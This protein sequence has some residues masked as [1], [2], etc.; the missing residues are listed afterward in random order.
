MTFFK[1]EHR[2]VLSMLMTVL[3]VLTMMATSMVAPISAFADEALSILTNDNDHLALT[4]DGEEYANLNKGVLSLTLDATNTNFVV[5]LTF[6]LSEVDENGKVSAGNMDRYEISGG[7]ITRQEGLVTATIDSNAQ[8]ITITVKEGATKDDFTIDLIALDKRGG[9]SQDCLPIPVKL[10]I[11][12]YSYTLE[13]SLDEDEAKVELTADKTE[14]SLDLWEHVKYTI[15]ET[16]YSGDD[17]TN[18]ELSKEEIKFALGSITQGSGTYTNDN[19]AIVL[20]NNLLVVNGEKMPGSEAGTLYK[21]ELKVTANDKTK[22]GGGGDMMS[23]CDLTVIEI[24]NCITETYHVDDSAPVA[25]AANQKTAYKLADVVKQKVTIKSELNPNNT[26]KW[27]EISD[28]LVAAIDGNITKFVKISGDELHVLTPT[29]E[30]VTGE[31]GL[32]LTID[33]AKGINLT[34]N[35]LTLDVVLND[36]NGPQYTISVDPADK[37]VKKEDLASLSDDTVT[38]VQLKVTVKYKDVG[39]EVELTSGNAIKY[40]LTY[41]QLTD[42]ADFTLSEVTPGTGVFQIEFTKGSTS[43]VYET[44]FKLEALTKDDYACMLTNDSNEPAAAVKFTLVGANEYQIQKFADV[45][46]SSA[47][48]QI[49]LLDSVTIAKGGEALAAADVKALAD[50]KE[51]KF[52]VH[53]GSVSADDYVTV[54]GTNLTLI[55][56]NLS[57]SDL[58]F[59]IFVQLS[60]DH[61]IGTNPQTATLKIVKKTVT[62]GGGD[63]SGASTTAPSNPSTPGTTEPEPEP[64]IPEVVVEMDP[65]TAETG[66]DGKAVAE[67][68]AKA[69]DEAIAEAIAEAEAENGAPVVSIPVEVDDEAV[70]LEVVLPTASVEKLAAAANS[71]LKVT[72]RIGDVKLSH[73]ALVALADEVGENDTIVLE[74]NT[75]V[76]A[77]A[78]SLNEAQ[79]DKIV[80]I[81]EKLGEEAEAEIFDV[82][83]YV[84]DEPMHDFNNGAI[85]VSVPYELPA[86]V[87]PTSIRVY[88]LAEDGTLERCKDAS[89]ADG[90]VTFTTYHL[91]KYIIS[92]MS[93][94]AEFED[95]AES[96][97]FYDAVMWAYENGVTTGKTNTEFDPYDG[98]TRAQF[99]T[100]LWRAAGYPEPTTTECAF[101]DVENAGELEP[102]YKAILWAAENGIALGTDAEGTTFSPKTVVLRGQAL[103]FMCRY[104]AQNN[105]GVEPVTP[106]F[107]DVQNEYPVDAYY[108]AIGWAVANGITNGLGNGL[109]GPLDACERGQMVTFLYRMFT[110][111]TV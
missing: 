81:V 88:Y 58:T 66:E 93:L 99:V 96:D 59:D 26:Y 52:Y 106:N 15:G 4:P 45:Q 33:S 74:I 5:E 67:V 55:K 17:L 18:G 65:V 24:T 91:S 87:A 71:A 12:P 31:I 69:M 43:G 22:P 21:I 82:S 102:Y 36:G 98:C 63:T 47:V 108:D 61:I 94:T 16:V 10:G 100:F 54:S 11:V 92:T 49:N 1:T 53:D 90:R 13:W 41:D 103:L 44:Q 8:K 109:F 27:D 50:S 46:L 23:V 80:E 29:N 37:T 56:D 79:L 75:G 70:D 84:N 105:I 60:V 101:T 35:E 110:D 83:L 78:E 40:A 76:D 85:E 32:T 20:N 28:E 34:P 25:L 42:D 62:T 57:D 30:E 6:E 77:V 39:G 68:D 9:T 2:R 72:S 14:F 73:T 95:V 107:T 64:E 104:A 89:Y 86:S 7:N 19:G 97:W 38:S 111:A 51:L 3:M 48:K